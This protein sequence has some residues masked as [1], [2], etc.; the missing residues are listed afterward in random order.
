M[1][2][3]QKAVSQ[4][5]KVHQTSRYDMLPGAAGGKHGTLAV[6]YLRHAFALGEHYNSVVPVDAS[7]SD[8]GGDFEE[9]AAK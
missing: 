3:Q 8:D 7:S 1:S 9:V 6:C 5:S 2:V 4:C